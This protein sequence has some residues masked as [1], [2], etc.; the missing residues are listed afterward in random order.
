MT[1]RLCSRYVRRRCTSKA[2]LEADGSCSIFHPAPEDF[3]N[4][5]RP[6]VESFVWFRVMRAVRG[7]AV[8]E[9]EKKR[10]AKSER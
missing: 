9:V 2:T 3:S 7:E 1:C 5:A 4:P 10:N 8:A 6:D